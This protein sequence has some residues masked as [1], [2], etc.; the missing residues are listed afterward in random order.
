MNYI[1][2]GFRVISFVL[3]GHLIVMVVHKVTH[4]RKIIQAVLVKILMNALLAEMHV[5]MVVFARTLMANLI[6]FVNPDLETTK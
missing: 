3:K 1:A 4:A 5:A 2:H 6:V